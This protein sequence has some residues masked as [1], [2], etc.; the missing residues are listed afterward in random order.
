MA[1]QKKEHTIVSASTGQQVKPGEVVAQTEQHTIVQAAPVGNAKKLRII[2]VVLWVAAIVLE[3]L[4]VWQIFQIANLSK[5]GIAVPGLKLAIVIGLIVLD[6]VC[7]IIG[8]QLWKRPTTS[9]PLRKPIP[10]SSGCGTT[11]A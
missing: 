1:K 5:A 8:A 2:A 7:V 11:W 6:A 9:T 10:P 4:A 3:V